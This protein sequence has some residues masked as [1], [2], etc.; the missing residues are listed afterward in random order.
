MAKLVIDHDEA[1]C[2]NLLHGNCQYIIVVLNPSETKH[3]MYKIVVSH[4]QNN[5]A[6]VLEATPH[7]DSVN[8]KEFKYFKFDLFGDDAA[9]VTIEIS[10]LHGDCD[11]YVSRKL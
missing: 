11:L 2:A 9:N 8:N 1:K 6:M 3:G 5:H 10:P 7:I 4:S